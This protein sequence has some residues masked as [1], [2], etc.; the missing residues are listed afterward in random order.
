L[1]QRRGGPPHQIVLLLPAIPVLALGRLWEPNMATTTL[2]RVFAFV[3]FSSFQQ[4]R[5][6]ADLAL[7]S[8]LGAARTTVANLAGKLI[9]VGL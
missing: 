8:V 6:K 1:Q 7:T 4:Y 5:S 3:Q 2:S 9:A